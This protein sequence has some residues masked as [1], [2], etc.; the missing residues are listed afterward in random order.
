[1]GKEGGVN[2]TS[3][4]EIRI[5]GVGNVMQVRVKNA[6]HYFG[7]TESQFLRVKLLELLDTLPPEVINFR[8]LER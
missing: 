5:T 8:G 3:G 7:V 2:K 4:R 1:M 6:A